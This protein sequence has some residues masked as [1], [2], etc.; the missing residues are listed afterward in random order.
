M[1]PYELDIDGLQKVQRFRHDLN[2][3][4]V[5][6]RDFEDVEQL[7]DLV[8]AH[9]F[10]LIVEEWETDKWAEVDAPVE[11]P[12]PKERAPRVVVDKRSSNGAK[13]RDRASKS[14]R[15][16]T[17]D[18][19][20]IEEPDEEDFGLLDHAEKFHSATASMVKT[21]SDMSTHI[22][23]IG[24]KMT[25]RTAEID[26]VMKARA[27]SRTASTNTQRTD[28]SRLKQIIDGA[29]R[30]VAD[31]VGEL[32]QDVNTYRSDNRVILAEL[33][34]MLSQRREFVSDGNDDQGLASLR[35]LIDTMKTVKSQVADFQKAMQKAP[36]LTK[37]FKSA[38]RQGV[39]MLGELIA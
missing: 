23:L 34:A 16:T 27:K 32:A 30:D 24:D 36:A 12:S 13:P 35:E 8:K 29:A 9:L 5:L 14:T 31:F 10:S 37:D 22:T 21:F 39:S 2:A 15:S 25:K 17:L 20:D 11:T 28:V 38:R 33:R 26:S 4:G 18:E 7:I 1:N 3:R 6:Y 19:E